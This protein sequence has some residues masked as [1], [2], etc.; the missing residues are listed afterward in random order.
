MS[1][2]SPTRPSE[3]D[4]PPTARATALVMLASLVIAGL[5]IFPSLWY[6]SAIPSQG[7]AWFAESPTV[8]GWT[9]TNIPVGQAAESILVA[10]RV[11][12]GTFTA[13]GREVKVY[14]AKR[15]LKKENEIGLFSHTPDRCWTAVG[16]SID[17]TDP[18][19]L[20]LPVHGVRLLLER[21]I[22]KA[23]LQRELVYFGALVGGRALPYRI[24]QYHAAGRK[25][26]AGGGDRAGT[27]QRLMQTR[28]W[29]WAW[30]SF[31]QRTPLS[32]PQQF[33]RISTPI[34]EGE[35]AADEL[36]RQFL[37]S[38]LVPASYE[39]ELQSFRQE[40]PASAPR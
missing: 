37:A 26:S 9:Y 18:D 36:L 6:R 23:G 27:W 3:R 31:S 5:W 30:E 16:W 38:W 10:D 34:R 7:Y 8:A 12:N 4:R 32:G 20:E 2:E 19:H 22:F 11:V 1:S 15:Y 29:S 28:L 33:V 21:R 25:R 24:D 39:G 14:S 40:P 17:P 35:A 13:P